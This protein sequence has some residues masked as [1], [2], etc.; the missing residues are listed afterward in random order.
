MCV[1]IV[2]S[3][4]FL[5]LDRANTD[6]EIDVVLD[7]NENMALVNA[8]NW[9]PTQ[10][11]TTASKSSLLQELVYE[12]LLEK[13]YK[14]ILDLRKGLQMFRLVSLMRRYPDQLRSLLVYGGS[15]LDA[16]TMLGLFQFGSREDE[17]ERAT[18]LWLKEYIKARSTE[19]EGV[20][21]LLKAHTCYVRFLMRFITEKQVQYMY[22]L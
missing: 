8:S 11:I 1:Y 4:L 20:F 16:E 5:Q 6:G 10:R 22:I 14:Q 13:R 2:S 17:R 12:E 18:L 3:Y 21:S 19:K 9:P 15:S 7:K